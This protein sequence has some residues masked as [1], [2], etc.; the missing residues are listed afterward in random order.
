MA[1]RQIVVLGH[2]ADRTGPPIYLLQLLRAL[3]L[4]R[5]QVTVVLLRGGELL[6][7]LQ[8]LAEVRVVGEPVEPARADAARL[9]EEPARLVARRAQLADLV[10]VPLVLVNTA[11]SIHALA[12]MPPPKVVVTIVHELEAGVAD[13]LGPNELDALLSSDRFVAGC[14][15]VVRMLVDGLEVDRDRI[16][17]IPYGVETGPDAV[18]VPRSELEAES[19]Q[20]LVVAAA[21]PD[22]RKGP[23]LFVHLAAAAHR[24]RPDVRWAFRWIGAHEDD[25]R[26][27]HAIE[28]R[29]LLGAGELVRFLPP[30]ATLRAWLACADAYVLPSRQD[31]FPLAAVE[32]ALAG[33]PL[34]CFASGG[35]GDLVADDA[36]A[37]V[38]YPD[39]DAMVGHLER[40]HDR[41]A[42]RSAAGAAGRRRALANHD[43][44]THAR[45]FRAEVIDRVLADGADR[46]I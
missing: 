19:D 24:R 11:W 29:A 39:L 13:L 9:A 14:R 41:P 35:I 8:E 20:F 34:L 25:P 38:P 18:P 44:A 10:D 42:E 16:D 15:A 36:G 37:L 3:D 33:L 26:L 40:W 2:A 7:D 22:R 23:D 27:A 28:D 43:V 17:L 30:T 5:G 4:P 32:A 12:W 6:S 1:D 46:P 45:R 31:A 21:V